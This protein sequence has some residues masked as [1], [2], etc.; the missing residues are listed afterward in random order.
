MFYG[1]ITSQDSIKQ[2]QDADAF[3]QYARRVKLNGVDKYFYNDESIGIHWSKREL[4]KYLDV[5]QDCDHLAV[6]QTDCLTNSASEILEIFHFLSSRNVTLHVVADNEKF[7][8]HEKVDTD[9]FLK[10]VLSCVDKSDPSRLEN[11]KQ[12]V[13]S[14]KWDKKIEFGSNL[15]DKRKLIEK[16]LKDGQSL[17]QIAK[18]VKCHEQIVLHYIKSNNLLR[19]RPKSQSRQEMLKAK[20]ILRMNAA[21]DCEENEND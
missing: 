9:K 4:K 14:K 13:L 3:Y 11:L 5:L 1:Y 10:L 7:E 20:A 12:T 17:I 6:M 21:N 19:L 8:A 15:E 2:A 18:I 16:S